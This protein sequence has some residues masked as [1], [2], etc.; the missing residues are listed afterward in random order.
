MLAE[1]AIKKK[2]EWGSCVL[3]L[4]HSLEYRVCLHVRILNVHAT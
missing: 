1:I 4:K 2:A 3:L